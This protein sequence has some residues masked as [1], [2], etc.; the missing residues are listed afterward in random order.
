MKFEKWTWTWIHGQ[1]HR[2][3]HG[4][5]HGQEHGDLDEVGWGHQERRHR[6]EYPRNWKKGNAVYLKPS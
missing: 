1:G 5:G 6:N 4:Q 2:Q 3:G